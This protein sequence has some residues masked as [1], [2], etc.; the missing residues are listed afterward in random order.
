MASVVRLSWWSWRSPQWSGIVLPSV[1]A[2]PASYDRA[3]TRLRI[4]ADPECTARHC[5]HDDR[6]GPTRRVLARALTWPVTP[7]LQVA[8]T[9]ALLARPAE[10]GPFLEPSDVTVRGRDDRLLAGRCPAHRQ[11]V[12]A[13]GR[14][15]VP[16]AERRA[17]LE[18]GHRRLR[19]ARADL[20]AGRAGRCP[21]RDAV[22]HELRLVVRL[23]HA[24]P[25][26]HA[27]RAGRRPG[28]S[29]R[30]R[31]GPWWRVSSTRSRHCCGRPRSTRRTR[32]S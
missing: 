19:R 31:G 10:A 21:R 11:G 6:M 3:G 25:P 27:A 20:A 16:R 32:T 14:L 18:R 29:G 8:T 12:R 26:V 23:P 28:S 13:A 22:R 17:G 15:G 4:S 2:L 1:R 9:A 30:C 5:C 24:R 7:V